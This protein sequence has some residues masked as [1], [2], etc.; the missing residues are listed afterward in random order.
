MHTHTHT[1]TLTHTAAFLVFLNPIYNYG[2]NGDLYIATVILWI[3]KKSCSI[4][5]MAPDVYEHSLQT[6][7]FCVHS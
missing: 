2:H 4:I 6:V 7:H 1:H 3:S 5:A